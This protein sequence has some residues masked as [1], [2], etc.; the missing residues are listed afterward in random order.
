MSNDQNFND[1]KNVSKFEIRASKFHERSEWRRVR[2]K[3]SQGWYLTVD[4]HFALKSEILNPKY[5]TILNDQNIYDQK[6]FR[7]SK[8]V[9]R[10]SSAK[11]WSPTYAEHVKS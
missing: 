7:N 8:F 3:T 4:Q 11:H 10:N 2:I 1:Q 9:L 6:M 5:E